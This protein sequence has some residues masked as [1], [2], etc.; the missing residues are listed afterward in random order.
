MK[1]NQDKRLFI[2][3]LDIT[4]KLLLPDCSIKNSCSEKLRRVIIDRRPDFDEHVTNFGNKASKKIQARAKIFPY[5]P[6]TQRKLLIDT[7]FLSQFG[8]S[9]LVWT[10]NYNTNRKNM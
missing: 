4:A 5:M 7:Y 8:Y 2:S 1:A 3:S 6:V 9:P 10:W